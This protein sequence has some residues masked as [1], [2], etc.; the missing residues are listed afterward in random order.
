[1]KVN[2]L[3]E[4]II[5]LQP[6]NPDK[7]GTFLSL[8]SATASLYTTVVTYIYSNN[9]LFNS[10]P[11]S[12]NNLDSFSLIDEN[13]ITDSLSINSSLISNFET[14]LLNKTS[15]S[16]LIYYTN[17]LYTN[18]VSD[19][20]TPLTS[21]YEN[22]KPEAGALQPSINLQNNYTFIPF[23]KE[24]IN[25]LIS[26]SLGNT[27]D[28]S[29]LSEGRLQF[30]KEIATS[31][32]NKI[33]ENNLFY[34]YSPTNIK[35]N[36]SDDDG[37]DST[38]GQLKTENI[39]NYYD[40]NYETQSK[41]V[42]E[43]LLPGVLHQVKLY[44][45]T[46][47]YNIT[48]I[49]EPLKYSSH[50]CTK[51]IFGNNINFSGNILSTPYIK[52][53][54]FFAN[55]DNSFGK[56]LYSN[57][58]A[59]NYI[60]GNYTHFNGYQPINKTRTEL[61]NT[62][63]FVDLWSFTNNL[64]S[65]TVQNILNPYIP[66]YSKV[67]FGIPKQ[68]VDFIKPSDG[69]IYSPIDDVATKTTFI[70]LVNNLYV[71]G[72]IV[73]EDKL[74][75][76]SSY[77][78]S[79]VN[80]NL[81]KFFNDNYNTSLTSSN[82]CE[83]ETTSNYEKIKIGKDTNT[84]DNIYSFISFYGSGTDRFSVV[85]ENKLDVPIAKD[86]QDE[87]LSEVVNITSTDTANNFQDHLL[88]TNNSY[89]IFLQNTGY[90]KTKYYYLTKISKYRVEDDGSETFVQNLYIDLRSTSL[91]F[92]IDDLTYEL[93]DNQIYSGTRY[94]YKISQFIIV[95]ALSYG[96]TGVDVVE[97]NGE[98]GLLVGISAVP[99]YK[100]IE[101]PVISQSDIVVMEKP[102]IT[103][104]VQFYPILNNKNQL[105]IQ[106]SPFGFD[107]IAQPIII[108]DSDA[109]LFDK[110]LE[111]Q[112]STGSLMFTRDYDESGVE[113]YEIYRTTTYPSSYA[114]FASNKLDTIDVTKNLIN[115]TDS[116]Q[117]NVP[118][119]YCIRS[120]NFRGLPSNPTKVYKVT[121][122]EDGEFYTLQQ[123][124]IEDLNAENIYNRQAIKDIKRFLY[125]TPSETQKLISGSIDG[126]A[127]DAIADLPLS[128]ASKEVWGKK[129]KIRV[130]SK[131]S[132]K[133]IDF[134][135]KFNKN[136]SGEFIPE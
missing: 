27:T 57:W 75:L 115:Y 1:M 49:F 30:A 85:L 68:E 98:L 78:T 110:A 50:F 10:S 106:I 47:Y 104:S 95:P 29:I 101:V 54:N 87:Y 53:Y 102:L 38:F 4:N 70:S 39:Y 74:I 113:F 71:D 65:K 46:S 41:L 99:I 45:Q 22:I 111:S 33:Q 121:L 105:I 82:I 63:L 6:D 58:L 73:D 123:E 86:E 118:Y 35:L 119:Y 14:S 34:Y 32:N 88:Q 120:K 5:N 93:F 17:N 36:Y 23:N 24:K 91:G 76:N 67:S 77:T 28:E 11:I 133:T 112:N 72:N 26:C 13:N 25:Q 107:K 136:N 109:T 66:Y 134:N 8:Y 79:S 31:L 64:Y 125:I 18:N 108:E 59:S 116:I 62:N 129:F 2:Q 43:R 130:T 3:V 117:V 122:V 69:T 97:K 114:S 94:N 126:N 127:T 60:S 92:P 128:I 21:L 12:I 124:V 51:Q 7:V 90:S 37:Y 83:E 9:S 61:T 96:Y 44:N 84:I 19:R 15:A 103:P 56:T 80:I 132:G 55:E 48:Q 100:L 40:E 16:P 89:L 135:I 131:S 81:L 52:N 42:D 20:Q